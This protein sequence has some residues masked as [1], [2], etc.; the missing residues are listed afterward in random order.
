MAPVETQEVVT[1]PLAEL[2]FISLYA[3]GALHMMLTLSL[4][5]FILLSAQ[6]LLQTLAFAAKKCSVVTG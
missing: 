2:V 1:S 6:K 3:G 5:P 4:V